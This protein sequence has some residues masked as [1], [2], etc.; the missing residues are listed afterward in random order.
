MIKSFQRSLLL[1]FIILQAI[2]V[3]I[4]Y[5][6]YILQPVVEYSQCPRCDGN[7]YAQLY[8]YLKGETNSLTIKYPFQNRPFVPYL[9]SRLPWDIFWNF[10]IINFIFSLLAVNSLYFLWKR[11]AIGLV[12]RCVGMFWLLLHWTDTPQCV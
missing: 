4:F 6:Y 1:E 8:Q 10:R 3:S 2:T 12:W 11:L 9:A 5:A 7:Q